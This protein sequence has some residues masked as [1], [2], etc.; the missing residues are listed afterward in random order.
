MR[1]EF[2]VPKKDRS[3]DLFHTRILV[4]R[5]FTDHMQRT[6]GKMARDAYGPSVSGIVDSVDMRA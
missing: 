5:S 1:P 4:R 6:V 3:W 2:G